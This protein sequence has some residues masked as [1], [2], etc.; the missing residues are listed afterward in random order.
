MSAHAIPMSS[1]ACGTTSG[2]VSTRSTQQLAV[3]RWEQ[4][5]DSPWSFAPLAAD[6]AARLRTHR[7]ALAAAVEEIDYREPRGD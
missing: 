4:P 5:V 2:A 6:L 7:D 1:I 3:V